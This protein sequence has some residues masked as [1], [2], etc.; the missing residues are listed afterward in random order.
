MAKGDTLLAELVLQPRSG[1]AGL[2]PRRARDLIDLQDPI[3]GAH[4]D[5]DRPTVGVADPRLHPADHAGAAAIRD[6]REPRVGAPAEHRLDLRFVTRMGDQVRR[7]VEPSPEAAHHVAIG[8]AQRV[9]GPL[10][11]IVPADPREGRWRLHPWGPELDRLEGHRLLDPVP[12]EPQPL[13]DP[14]GSRLEVRARE[15]AVLCAPPPVLAAG[16][17]GAYQCTPRIR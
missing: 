14:G 3:Q 13:A 11:R 8:L 17:G 10:V 1:R 2:D 5:R 15:L 4:V 12:P 7:I 6:R 16:L 9:R